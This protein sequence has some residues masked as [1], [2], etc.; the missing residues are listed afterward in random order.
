MGDGLGRVA[1]A[2]Y[3]ERERRERDD[4]LLSPFL[5]LFLMA[6]AQRVERRRQTVEELGPLRSFYLDGARVHT[7]I[8]DIPNHRVR[9]TRAAQV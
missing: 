6:M 2:A 3:L 7:I 9:Y 4:T 1:H 5:P 8:G